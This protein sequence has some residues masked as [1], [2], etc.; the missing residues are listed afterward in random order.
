MPDAPQFSLDASLVRRHFATA[1]AQARHS[2]FVAREIASR[3]AER[4]DYIRLTPARVLDL[5]CGHGADLT[6]LAARYPQALRVGV[7]L[8]LPQ[9]AAARP[10]RTLLQRLADR[11]GGPPLVCADAARLPFA[12]A[13][14]QLVWSNLALNWL[15][16]PADA[17]REARRVLE[18]GGLLMF[19]TFG[20]DT[21]RE[22]RAAWRDETGR[23]VH[24]FIDMH[25]LGD[26]L[27]GAGFADPVMDMQILTLTY[28]DARALFAELRAT[29]S[30]N[31]S[32]LRPRGLTG[33]ARWQAMLDA[34][35]AQR[36]QGR[37]PATLEIVFGHAWKAEPR[38]AEDG[39]PIVRFQPRSTA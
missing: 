23:R 25:D 26:L 34:L 15:S 33:R 18:V 7:D 22:L 27:V 14:F 12:R 11:H 21:L 9:L 4:L 35:D 2:D 13:S 38:H 37:V 10:P 3:M 20:P 36:L 30:T 32:A 17:I 19:S 39:R 16:D 8:S 24:R 28:D 6:M 29:G 31:A 1:A 5:G